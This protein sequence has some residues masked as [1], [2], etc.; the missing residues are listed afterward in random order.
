[1]MGKY[2]LSDACTSTN[3]KF[4]LFNVQRFKDSVIKSLNMDSLK[5]EFE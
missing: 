4:Y 5:I 1:M 2:F 3:V